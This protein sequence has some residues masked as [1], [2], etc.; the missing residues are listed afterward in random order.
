MMKMEKLSNEN[1]HTWKQRVSLAISFRDLDG[2]LEDCGAGSADD[3]GV[4]ADWFRQ[5]R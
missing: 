5:N 1:F 4:K 3:S 2:H